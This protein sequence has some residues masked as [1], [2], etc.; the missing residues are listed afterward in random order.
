[1]HLDDLFRKILGRNNFDRLYK[2]FAFM[3]SKYYFSKVSPEKRRKILEKWFLHNVGYPLNLDDPKTYNE[4]LQWS[5]LYDATPLKG[6][7]SDKYAVREY[8]A[9]KLGEEYLIPLL[10]KYDSFDE[11]DIDALPERFVLKTNHGSGY[12]LI[13][14]DKSLVDW[15]AA[16]KNFDRWLKIDFGYS[17]WFQLHYSFIKPCIIAEKYMEYKGELLDYKFACFDGKVHFVWVDIGRFTNHRRNIYDR[18]WNLMP[19]YQEYKSDPE[20]KI[21]KPVNFEKMIEFAE[22]LSEG[23]AHVR[24]DFYEVD[25]QI[26]FGELTFTSENGKGHFHPV[27]IDREWGDL[28]KLP[29]E[30]KEFING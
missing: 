21:E 2:Q 22:K 15:K 29:E 27:E 25:G 1:M 11:I 6:M 14:K 18:N 4:K 8:I 16:K 24:V 30:K 20:A 7:L 23:F 26:Y 10:G 17:S 12:N 9:D 13:V 28:F 5:K 19:Y 3:R